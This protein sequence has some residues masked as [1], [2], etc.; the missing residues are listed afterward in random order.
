MLPL[1]RHAAGR[2]STAAALLVLCGGAAPGEEPVRVEVLSGRVF[3]GTIEARTDASQLWLRCGDAQLAVVRPIDWERIAAAEV[4]GRRLTAEAFRTWAMALAAA[5]AA[6]QNG[7]IEP[8]VP[9]DSAPQVD[10]GTSPAAPPRT[11]RDTTVPPALRDTTV[12]P[13]L[14]DT[15]VPPRIQGPHV[16]PGVWR[17]EPRIASIVADAYL[18]SWNADPLPDG[19]V[20]H[21]WP[22]GADGQI[23]PV[24]GTLEVTL[25]A[26]V[27][28][29]ATLQTI[30]R[31]SAVVR[32]WDYGPQGA[33]MRL[34]F[35]GVHPEVHTEVATRGVVQVKFTVP[36]HGVYHATL[37]DVRIRQ[38]SAVRDRVQ[39][40]TGQRLLPGEMP[41]AR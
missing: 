13:P 31:G 41:P 16:P 19:L 18:A 4:A 24:G 12:P 40:Q 35:R 33:V 27:G 30:V 22:L 11:P 26:A 1:L 36:G 5:R 9:D 6:P 25:L 32:P 23:W 3:S 34:A 17:P 15:T 37:S 20:L 2:W 10:G 39:Q 7:A 21:V 8:R 28:R 29:H 14:R 38:A